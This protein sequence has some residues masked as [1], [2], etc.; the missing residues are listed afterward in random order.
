MAPGMPSAL[1]SSP[2]KGVERSMYVSHGQT[3]ASPKCPRTYPS[4]R[5]SGRVAAAPGSGAG[6]LVLRA[7]DAQ[8][9]GAKRSI[10][11]RA[12]VRRSA[13]RIRFRLEV[14][15]VQTEVCVGDHAAPFQVIDQ[16][17]QQR[18]QRELI[19]GG[20]TRDLFV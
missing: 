5:G 15:A 17:Q 7:A 20:E 8:I 2:S 19:V 6:V 13:A 12:V 9:G 3:A 16:P 10:E 18:H 14:P 11:Q 4:A 1:L